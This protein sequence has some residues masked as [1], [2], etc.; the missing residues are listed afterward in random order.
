MI[1]GKRLRTIVLLLAFAAGPV[2][3]QTVPYQSSQRS[4]YGNVLSDETLPRGGT[5]LFRVD[6]AVQYAD[7]LALTDDPDLQVSSG[8]LELSPGFY[9]SY[10]GDVSRGRSITR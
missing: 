7:N 4:Q 8:G 9:A 3:A 6:A 1:P 2:I 5:F 10:G